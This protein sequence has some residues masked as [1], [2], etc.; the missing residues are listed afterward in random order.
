MPNLQSDVLTQSSLEQC[1]VIIPREYDRLVPQALIWD[2]KCNNSLEFT[3]LCSETY[4][5]LTLREIEVDGNPKQV[6]YIKFIENILPAQ[7]LAIQNSAAVLA[8]LEPTLVGLYKLLMTIHNSATTVKTRAAIINIV[9]S[10]NNQNIN[11]VLER[12]CESESDDKTDP[13]YKYKLFIS[14]YVPAVCLHSLEFLHKKARLAVEFYF[15]IQHLNKDI[16]KLKDDYQLMLT[17][18]EN[19]SNVNLLSHH[20]MMV[21]KLAMDKLSE[22]ATLWDENFSKWVFCYLSDE[23]QICREFKFDDSEADDDDDDNMAAWVRSKF[24]YNCV[25][26]IPDIHPQSLTLFKNINKDLE[27]IISGIRSF[28]PSP[29]EI[30]SEKA[31]YMKPSITRVRND[32]DEYLKPD[33]EQTT[34]IG[35]AKSLLEQIKSMRSV[36]DS[37]QMSGLF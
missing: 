2:G 28:Q 34:T 21:K 22:Y 7:L 26:H 12:S 25:L 16:E 13:E 6:L 24:V 1:N 3:N 9:A 32:A 35:K 18:L 29:L 33:S 27:P 14:R 23:L 36:I 8:G 15:E 19:R 20:V 10:F 31:R 37:L 17:S 30:A 4:K 11:Q 5:L